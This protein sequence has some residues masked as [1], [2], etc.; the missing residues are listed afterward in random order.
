MNVENYI[1]GKIQ[2]PFKNNL[3][4]ALISWLI[5]LSVILT[6]NWQS[7]N[8]QLTVEDFPELELTDFSY[9]SRERREIFAN[10]ELQKSTE[11]FKIFDNLYY[12]G[13]EWVS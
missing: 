12:V 3:K 2:M 10:E 7:A 4:R 5:S 11:P 9:V 13:I 8:A 6:F 1:K